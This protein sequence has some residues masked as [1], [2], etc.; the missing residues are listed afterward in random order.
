MILKILTLNNLTHTVLFQGEEKVSEERNPVIEIGM[1]K[2][3]GSFQWT[4]SDSNGFSAKFHVKHVFYIIK[5][6]ESLNKPIK[7]TGRKFFSLLAISRLS[8][9]CTVSFIE[10]L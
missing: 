3:I 6:N 9:I 2:I 7:N 1:M 8:F 4:I 10:F 5:K